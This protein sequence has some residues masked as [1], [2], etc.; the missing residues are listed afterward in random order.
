MDESFAYFLSTCGPPL[1]RREVDPSYAAG[2]AGK[3]PDRLREYWVEHGFTGYA[4]GRFWTVDPADYAGVLRTWL[5]SSP[6]HG[7]DDYHVIARTA[8]GSLFVWGTQSG[9]S[10]EI[11]AAH[12]IVFPNPAAATYVR[13]GRPEIA[14]EAFFVSMGAGRTDFAD[15][16]GKPLF[17]RARKKLGVLAAGEMYG[18]VP[19]LA[20]GGTASVATLEKV[21]IIEHLDILAQLGPLR[22]F[23]NPL[24]KPGGP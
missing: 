23:E 17:A 10:L 3:L 19:A 13:E 11:N 12:G 18:F 2:Y 1:A 9:V 16:A 6:F 7:V 5:A 8:F 21:A 4:D 22:I 24:L 14:V 20:L 15:D